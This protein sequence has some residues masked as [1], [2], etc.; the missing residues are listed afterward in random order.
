V[1]RSS[2]RNKLERKSKESFVAKFEV[3][4]WRERRAVFRTAGVR[5]EDKPGSTEREAGDTHTALR[6]EVE[7][8]SKLK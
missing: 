2:I 5:N 8:R 1:T 4:A 7:R 3:F 6:H